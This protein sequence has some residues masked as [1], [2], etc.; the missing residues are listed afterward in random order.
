MSKLNLSSY[1]VEELN[2]QEMVAVEGGKW[3]LFGKNKLGNS[4]WFTVNLLGIPLA[5][6]YEIK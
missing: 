1:G 4:K 2:Q 5:I 6:G 3:A